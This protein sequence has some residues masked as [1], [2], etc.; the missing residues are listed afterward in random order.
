MLLLPPVQRLVARRLRLVA[1]HAAGRRAD[2]PAWN[3][4]RAQSAQGWSSGMGNRDV[5]RE[6]IDGTWEELPPDDD[7]RPSSGW[8][9]H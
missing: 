6:V 1:L 4:G 9:R 8:T 5:S 2:A 7:N 3:R